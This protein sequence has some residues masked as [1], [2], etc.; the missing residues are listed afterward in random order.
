[1]CFKREYKCYK[2]KES[3][4]CCQNRVDE[5]VTHRTTIIMLIISVALLIVAL[6]VKAA[7]NEMFVG[8]VS[9]ASTVTSIVLSVIAIWMSISGER[10]TSEIKDKV[11]VASDKLAETVNESQK[12][13]NELQKTLEQQNDMYIRLGDKITN[14]DAS[15]GEMKA[16][17]EGTTNKEIETNNDDAYFYAVMDGLKN[18]E[19][20][21]VLVECICKVLQSFQDDKTNKI[22]DTIHKIC[23]KDKVD[24]QTEGIIVGIICVFFH[25]KFFNNKENVT[26][27]ERYKK[28]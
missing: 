6:T 8:Q 19:A 1:M 12:I 3:E 16:L 11:A 15:I 21:D 23:R 28:E 24:E 7:D 10:Q 20:I 14:V 2:G 13:M 18:W 17:F 4:D 5:A 9:F 22:G 27:I 26:K 25:N